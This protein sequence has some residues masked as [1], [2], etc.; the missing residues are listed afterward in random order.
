MDAT[1]N[2]MS[3]PQGK[4]RFLVIRMSAL[5]VVLVTETALT[6]SLWHS[7][8]LGT[9]SHLRLILCSVAAGLPLLLA[10]TI[11]FRHRFR[12]SLRGLLMI[13]A[14]VAVFMFASVRPLLEA[15]DARQGSRLL[16]LNG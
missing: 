13:M 10:A 8:W 2:G 14:L 4:A 3:M 11:L 1:R 7:G 15:F 6:V 16:T 5:L 12:F 9:G